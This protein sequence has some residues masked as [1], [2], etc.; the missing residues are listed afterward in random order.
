MWADRVIM[1]AYTPNSAAPPLRSGHHTNPWK[2]SLLRGMQQFIRFVLWF[3]LSL[4]C[5]MAC[6]FSICFVYQFL[7]H[8]W[9]WC[10][11]T[12]FSHDW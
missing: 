12:L 10:M 7:L 2:A 6:V 5:F 1:N 8:S 3:C 4:N 11:R 9:R